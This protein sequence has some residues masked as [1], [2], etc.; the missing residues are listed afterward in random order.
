MS[1]DRTVFVVDD[2][3]DLRES[4]CAL[5]N[6]MGLQ[7]RGFSSAEAFLADHYATERAWS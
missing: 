5:V 2:D 7:G 3:M 1:E 4:V 6:S